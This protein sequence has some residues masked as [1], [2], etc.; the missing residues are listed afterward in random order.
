MMLFIKEFIKKI[1]YREKYNSETY[2]NWL[3]KQGIKIGGGQ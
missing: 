2:I 3:R 1:L